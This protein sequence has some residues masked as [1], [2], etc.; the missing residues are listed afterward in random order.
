MY[1]KCSPHWIVNLCVKRM[2]A[3]YRSIF[4]LLHC[5]SAYCGSLWLAS[6]CCMVKMGETLN[7]PDVANKFS[8]LLTKAK[9]SFHKKLWNG[10]FW[11]L[12]IIQPIN[13]YW[14]N[15]YNNVIIII[16]LILYLIMFQLVSNKNTT[17]TINIRLNTVLK[18][19][20]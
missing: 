18:L 7:C 15:N 17:I 14:C 10:E 6:L 11:I 16:G 3:L 8:A 4:L 12:C 1:I 13:L 5:C 2:L 19:R 20:F 9:A